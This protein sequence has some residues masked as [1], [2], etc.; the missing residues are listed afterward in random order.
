MWWSATLPEISDAG[1]GISA[2]GN[3]APITVLSDV[4]CILKCP[5]GEK[6]SVKILKATIW[7]KDN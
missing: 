5:I 7:V 6:T 3:S 1:N 2:L 4:K